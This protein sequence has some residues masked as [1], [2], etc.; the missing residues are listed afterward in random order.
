MPMGNTPA[1]R[2]SFNVIFVGANNVQTTINNVISVSPLEILYPTDPNTG[3]STGR[4]IINPINIMILKSQTDQILPFLGNHISSILVDV[5]GEVPVNNV[6]TP[7]KLEEYRLTNC[8][9]TKIHRNIIINQSIL[10]NGLVNV[11]DTTSGVFT[12][13]QYP[14]NGQTIDM[15]TILPTSV[16]V[17]I[18]GTTKTLV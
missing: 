14:N 7:T 2:V 12:Q 18:N 10:D 9:I 6:L 1:K 15:F 13:F 17:T 8:T 16:S 4:S 3:Q 5:M 11:Y